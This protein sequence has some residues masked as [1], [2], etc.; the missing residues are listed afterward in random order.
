MFNNPLHQF[1]FC[2]VLANLSDLQGCFRAEMFSDNLAFRLSVSHLL[3]K[4]NNTGFI[5]MGIFE[6][7]MKLQK[8]TKKFL[9]N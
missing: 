2:I 7:N 4:D 5:I 8:G 9:G 3:Y 6:L 1:P